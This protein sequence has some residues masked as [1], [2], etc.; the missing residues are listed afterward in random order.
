MET[1]VNKNK[2]EL[3][4]HLLGFHGMFVVDNLD[5]SGGLVLFW[6][7]GTKVNITGHFH[8]HIDPTIRLEGSEILW[9]LTGFY[10]SPER[11]GRERGERN[12]GI[13]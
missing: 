4:K 2:L 1:L 13:F 3:I 5:H 10:G 8:N 12:P 9:H 7:K 11:A 6:K